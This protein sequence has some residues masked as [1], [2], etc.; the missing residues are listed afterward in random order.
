MAAGHTLTLTGYRMM[1][2]GLVELGR[3]ARVD[4]DPLRQYVV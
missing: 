4:S 1:A 2:D 3:P